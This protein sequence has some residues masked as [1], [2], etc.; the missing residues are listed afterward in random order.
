MPQLLNSVDNYRIAFLFRR[1]HIGLGIVSFI[2]GTHQSL[3]V[4]MAVVL[5]LVVATTAAPFAV[6][7]SA[8]DA[9]PPAGSPGRWYYRGGGFHMQL[10]IEARPW[11]DTIGADVAVDKG[12]FFDLEEVRNHFTVELVTPAGGGGE[13]VADVTDG[14]SLTLLES[15]QPLDIEAPV[16]HTPYA[17]AAVRVAFRNDVPAVSKA[18]GAARL[19]LVLPIHGRYPRAY[20]GPEGGEHG[21]ILRGD[22]PAAALS[23]LLHADP[24]AV[25]DA[26]LRNMTLRWTSAACGEGSDAA[27]TAAPLCSPIPMGELRLLPTVYV[28][29]MGLLWTG[30]M[31]VLGC[32]CVPP[33][34]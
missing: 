15:E 9:A 16:F 18:D 4:M 2:M 11:M 19:R 28:T 24:R 5:A 31:I 27:G 34:W 23:S 8:C 12:L 26:C 6:A 20:A 7:A 13:V 14:V 21:N 17:T 10:V 22:G 33:L 25:V 3:T 1:E 30:A 32:F 29:L